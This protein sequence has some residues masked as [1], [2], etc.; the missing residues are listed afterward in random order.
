V[1]YVDPDGKADIPSSILESLKSIA[2][3][4]YRTKSID[5]VNLHT[6][7][8]LNGCFAR[9]SLIGNALIE[10]GYDVSYAHTVKPLHYGQNPN[11][12]NA[13]RFNFHV[14]AAVNI[15]GTI[16]IIDPYYSGENGKGITT[17]DEWV[18]K[19]SPL[20]HGL[21]SIDEYGGDPMQF[22]YET[23]NKNEKLSLKEYSAGWLEHYAK[24]GNIAWDGLKE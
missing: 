3:E 2:A 12:P 6:E 4:L 1:K 11:D 15:D 19:Q 24:T 23:Y 5:G 22:R 20:E 21:Y 8:S 13:K 18:Q 9:A 14:A 10:R 17:Y 7:A 16:Y